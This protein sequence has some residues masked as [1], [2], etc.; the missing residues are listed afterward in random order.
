[1]K[2]EDVGYVGFGKLD[3]GVWEMDAR[4]YIIYGSSVST[5]AGKEE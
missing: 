5:T 3:G 2:S 4:I 1:M